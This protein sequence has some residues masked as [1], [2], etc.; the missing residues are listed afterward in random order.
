MTNS[1]IR[2]RISV[3]SLFMG[4]NKFLWLSSLALRTPKV[5]LNSI[6]YIDGY[7]IVA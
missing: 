3:G 1:N 4:T 6:A 7:E 2:A 5:V